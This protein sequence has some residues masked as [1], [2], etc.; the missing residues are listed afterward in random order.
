[1]GHDRDYHTQEQARVEVFEYI[2]VFYNL[3]R[4]H[5]ALGYASPEQFEANNLVP[6][7]PCPRNLG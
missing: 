2:E 6:F 4:V 5:Q 7:P 1:L 3:Q